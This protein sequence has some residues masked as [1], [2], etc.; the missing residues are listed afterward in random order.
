TPL[1]LRRFLEQLIPA[2]HSLARRYNQDHGI[3]RY[4][5]GLYRWPYEL[6]GAPWHLQM[7][8]LGNADGLVVYVL[9][10]DD[11]ELA[12][13]LSYIQPNEQVVY[14]LPQEPMRALLETLRE[15]F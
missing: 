7:E 2:P 1:Q 9:A 4:F 14:V 8:Q 6:D 15:F 11:L 3:T 12:Q 10:T 13:A 5:T